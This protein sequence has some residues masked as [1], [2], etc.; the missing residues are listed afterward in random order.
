MVL[1]GEKFK[2]GQVVCTSGVNALMQEDPI[3]RKH[4]HECLV[5]HLLGDCGDLGAADREAN[6]RALADGTRLFS[7]YLA[8]GL[9]KI[10]IIT[11]ADR[12][13]TT[14]LFPSEY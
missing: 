6:N 14:V 9:P 1:I 10:W 13:A 2:S 11:E 4:A 7:A 8:Q 12:S 3:F 5:R